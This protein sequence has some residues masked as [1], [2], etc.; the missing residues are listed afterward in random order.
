MKRKFGLSLGLLCAMNLWAVDY[1]IVVVGGTPGGIMSAVAAARE[2]K[3]VVLLERT[4]HVGGLP[5]NGL[6][7]TDIATREATTGLFREFTQ[8]V[9]K[10]YISRYGE[11]SEQVKYCSDGFHFEPQV[12]EIVFSDMLDEHSGKI[13]VLT[14]RQFD[15]EP[16]NI[17]MDNEEIQSIRVQNRETG[18]REQYAGRI[19]VDATYEG[20]LGAAAG[21]P[22]RIGRES[23]SEFNEPGR[24]RI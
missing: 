15:A 10:Y 3:S 2:G 11:D 5:A 9:K 13:D 8:R 19:F 18:N 23:K 24:P 16:Q 22:F 12:A 17:V 4:N 14:M 20:D 6:G 21:V 1:D 7:A